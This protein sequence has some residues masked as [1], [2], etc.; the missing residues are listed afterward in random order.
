MCGRRLM[1]RLQVVTKTLLMKLSG[2]TNFFVMTKKSMY[3]IDI[4]NL[5]LVKITDLISAINSFLCEFSSFTNPEQRFFLMSI[6][7]SI[8]AKWRSLIKASANVISANP[9][10]I[11][12][13][14]KLPSGNVVPILDI[15]PK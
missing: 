14:I 4:V 12:P 15:S 9:L 2:T 11:T 8:H 5:V 10:P 1:G 6:V 3:R 7:N 13:T